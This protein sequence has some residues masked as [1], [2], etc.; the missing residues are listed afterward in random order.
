MERERERE[1]SG[2]WRAVAINSIVR[3]KLPIK[4]ASAAMDRHARTWP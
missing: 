3:D 1:E 4:L 2:D